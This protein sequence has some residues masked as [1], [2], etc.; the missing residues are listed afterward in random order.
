MLGKFSCDMQV[1]ILGCV[2]WL[3]IG[4][5]FVVGQAGQWSERGFGENIVSYFGIPNV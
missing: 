1:E 2:C 5:S 4:K 3:V